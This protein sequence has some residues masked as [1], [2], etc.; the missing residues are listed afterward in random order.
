MKK[1]KVISAILALCILLGCCCGCGAEEGQNADS[2]PNPQ[3][4]A[5]ASTPPASQ[6]VTTSDDVNP[7]PA[8]TPVAIPL[9]DKWE[10]NTVTNE[11]PITPEGY[12]GNKVTLVKRYTGKDGVTVDLY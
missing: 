3:P 2:S 11:V 9:V 1:T 5:S 4:E 12:E 8:P 7:E 6:P 10:V